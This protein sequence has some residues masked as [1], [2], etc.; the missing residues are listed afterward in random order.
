MKFNIVFDTGPTLT[1]YWITLLC[2]LFNDS[3]SHFN[4]PS[5]PFYVSLSPFNAYPLPLGV[6]LS[7]L[8]PVDFN[9]S[10]AF[11]QFSVPHNDSPSYFN[12]PPHHFTLLR[13]LLLP[14]YWPLTFLNCRYLSFPRHP[15]MA[16]HQL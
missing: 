4:R 6:L 3:P 11:Q 5:S 10:V 7:P 15:L 13:R 1:Q 12:A 8:I 16:L 9:S 14:V 2:L